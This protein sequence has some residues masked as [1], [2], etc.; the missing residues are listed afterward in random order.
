M[1]LALALVL[2]LITL[3]ST[4]LFAGRFWW[5]PVLASQ[6]GGAIDQQIIRTFWLCGIIF[7]AAQLGLAWAIFRYRGRGQRADYSHGNTT[8]EAFWTAATAI[9]FI[10]INLLGQKVWAE[11]MISRAAPGAL[12]VEVTGQQFA[13][14]VRYPGPDGKFGR[15]DPKFVNDSA[16]DP[17]GVD[18]RDPAGKDDIT[19]PTMAVPVNRQVEIILRSKDV[20]H[21]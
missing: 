21:A 12:R 6:H 11:R 2:A 19:V 9:L 1:A 7:L 10:G 14:N 4:V 8:L 17:V 15:T 16:G 3:I 18:P 20:T 5:F 13:W